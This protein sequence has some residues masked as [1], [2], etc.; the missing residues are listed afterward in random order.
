M[1]VL[2]INS[3]G[4]PVPEALARAFSGVFISVAAI[5]VNARLAIT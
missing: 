1:T 4:T 2:P 3:S 5:F